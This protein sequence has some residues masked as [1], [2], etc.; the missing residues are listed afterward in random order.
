MQLFGFGN[1]KYVT[2]WISECK[3]CNYYHSNGFRNVKYA[4]IWISECKIYNYL[5]FGM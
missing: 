1:V 3:I 2:I 4:T 5:D